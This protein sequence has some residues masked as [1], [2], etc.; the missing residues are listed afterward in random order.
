[1]RIIRCNR[2][3]REIPYKDD[4]KVG[5]IDVTWRDLE[6]DDIDDSNPFEDWDFCQ[7]CVEEIKDFI[8]VKQEDALML[9]AKTDKA[10]EIL[11]SVDAGKR[12][13]PEK[14]TGPHDWDKGKAQAIRDAYWPLETIA[15]EL[16]TTIYAIR[17][18]T[19]APPPRKRYPNEWA[20]GEP[21]LAPAIRDLMG[22]K[23]VEVPVE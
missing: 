1:M 18:H 2:C 17:K 11:E 9:M 14:K 10:E 13:K 3:G 21:N 6:R 16:G 15:S 19:T 4:A 20:E 23:H 12:K 5:Y 7:E 22:E 8:R